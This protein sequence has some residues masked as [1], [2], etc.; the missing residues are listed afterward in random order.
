[1]PEQSSGNQLNETTQ[2]NQKPQSN[3][4]PQSNEILDAKYLLLREQGVPRQQIADMFGVS[5]RQVMRGLERARAKIKEGTEERKPTVTTSDDDMFY[6]ITSTSQNRK[7]IISKD[8]LRILKEL[9]CREKLTIN[10]TCRKLNIPRRDFILIKTAFNITHDDTPYIDEDM[11][12]RPTEELV[13]ETL[14][15]SKE[16]YF[17][18]LQ[19]QEVIALRREVNQYRKQ[20]Y[21]IN[22]YTKEIQETMSQLSKNYTG[23]PTFKDPKN[24]TTTIKIE[25]KT[26]ILQDRLLLVV[27]IMDMHL[28]K[29]AWKPETGENYD[30][31]ICERLFINLIHEHIFFSKKHRLPIERIVFPVGNDFFNFDNIEQSTTAGTKQDTD[32][33]W[34]KLPVVGLKMLLYA[35]DLLT[36]EFEAPIEV[37]YIPGN[38]DQVS[39]YSAILYLS[40][41][42]KSD[43]HVLINTSPQTRKYIEYGQNLL[44]FTH[45]DKEKSRIF[46]LM[47]AEAPAAWGRTRYHE[48]LCGHFHHEHTKEN[49]GVKVKYLPSLVGTDS[50]HFEHGFVGSSPMHTSLIYHHQYGLYST[51]NFSLEKISWNNPQLQR[52]LSHE[53]KLPTTKSQF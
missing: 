51:M 31:K 8:K 22:L 27:P 3:E 23:P 45:G 38:H 4:S 50:Y 24:K 53:I 26:K 46:G 41:W 40:A 47:Q 42:Y 16:N 9:Y 49:H 30:Y 5:L 34:Q 25:S 6:I 37:F 36:A 21:W 1:M 17:L 44:G 48:F 10:A 52:E 7:V 33:R 39:S 12:E 18:K 13:E 11:L 29:L 2:P 32:M 14:E 28:G 15:K 35:I 43:D 19:E 20:E